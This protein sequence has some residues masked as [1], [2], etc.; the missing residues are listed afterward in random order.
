MKMN[1]QTVRTD[2]ENFEVR[3]HN[4]ICINVISTYLT[5]EQE[6]ID[7]LIN[8]TPINQTIDNQLEVEKEIVKQIIPYLENDTDEL[9]KLS[10]FYTTP[11]N[12]KEELINSGYG[13]ILRTNS[14]YYFTPENREEFLE[15]I[16]KELNICKKLN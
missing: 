8:V 9:L 10:L 12:S 2:I 14:K 13:F 4:V 7:C 3:K 11:F 6:C 15:E 16:V 5:Q 1:S